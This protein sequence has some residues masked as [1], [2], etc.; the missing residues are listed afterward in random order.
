MSLN[1]SGIYILFTEP[2][3]SGGGQSGY[4][5]DELLND[6][7]DPILQ[8][9]ADELLNSDGDKVLQSPFTEPEQLLNSD[10]DFVN[11]S[12]GHFVMGRGYSDSPILSTGNKVTT[13]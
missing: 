13:K 4:D 7:G 3:I 9:G 8:G 12:D 11:N 1:Q 10:G 5:Q 2:Q 6:E